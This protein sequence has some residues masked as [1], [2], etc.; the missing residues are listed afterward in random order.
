MPSLCLIGQY[1]I[2]KGSDAKHAKSAPTLLPPRAP[3]P[4]AAARIHRRLKTLSQKECTSS[5]LA[6]PRPNQHWN[7]DSLKHSVRLDGPL[8]WVCRIVFL[9]VMI[10][11]SDSHAHHPYTAFEADSHVGISLAWKLS[12]NHPKPDKQTLVYGEAGGA[13]QKRYSD[14]RLEVSWDFM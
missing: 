9:W 10:D 6:S 11:G 5:S 13:T 2:F 14:I 8:A 12:E 3:E 7:L 4:A 1:F